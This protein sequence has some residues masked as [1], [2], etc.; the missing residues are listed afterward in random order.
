M[1]KPLAPIDAALSRKNLTP[2]W[3]AAC[4]AISPQLWLPTAID[5][6]GSVLTLSTVGLNA[7]VDKSW[8][9]SNLLTPSQPTNWYTT[10]SPFLVPLLSE[11]TPLANTVTKSKKI[12][13]YPTKEQRF[14]FRRWL[15]A[16]RYVYNQTLAYLKTLE[17]NAPSWMEIAKNIIHPNL[18]EWSEEIPYQIKKIAV[19][20]ACETVRGAK[21]KFRRTG[22]VSKL[23]FKSRKSPVQTCYIPKSAVTAKGIYHTLSGVLKY[24]EKLPVEFQ[25]CQLSYQ[26]G[27][28][29]LC[30]PY[31]TTIGSGDNQARIVALDPGVRTFLTFFSPDMA[32]V[33]GYHDFG[34][35][36]RLCRYL[37]DLISR[38]STSKDKKQRYRMRKAANRMRWK[39]RDLRNELHAKSARFLVDNF[40]IILIPTFE[41]S[42]MAKRER[43]KLNSKTVRAML[44]WGHFQ[45]KNRL[46]DVALQANKTVIEVREDYTSKTCSWSGEVVRAGSSEIIRGSDGVQMHRDTNGARGIFLRALV[47]LPLLENIQHAVASN[48]NN[49]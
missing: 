36:V 27:R 9:T 6:H 10:Y 19:K 39:I 8:F 29:F 25:D 23:H 43:R 38:Y 37:D 11:C 47:E 42:Q 12:R 30:V 40:D 5:S 45:F 2:Y 3:N 46:K 31:Q 15:G 24:T 32:G 49:G 35:L 18:P 7:T 22:E 33:L 16:Y 14:I 13:L 17:D 34:R 41:T 1:R 28:W 4:G 20:E 21:Q 44:T 48:A 26:Q